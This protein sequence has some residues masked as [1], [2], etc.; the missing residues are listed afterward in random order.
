MITKTKKS[1]RWKGWPTVGALQSR[2][3]HSKDSNNCSR[4]GA[5]AATL[6]L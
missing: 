3:Q 1:I 2:Y 4:A 6:L 5:R